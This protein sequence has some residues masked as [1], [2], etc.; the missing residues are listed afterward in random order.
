MCFHGLVAVLGLPALLGGK[1][2]DLVAQPTLGVGVPGGGGV[3]AVLVASFAPPAGY[4]GEGGG[5]RGGDSGG[6]GA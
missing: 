6:R 5:V 1:D 4:G 3:L 2:F